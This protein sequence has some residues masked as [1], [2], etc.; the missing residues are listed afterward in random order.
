MM[1]VRIS[2]PL[3]F[4]GLL[5]GTYTIAQET[6]SKEELLKKARTTVQADLQESLEKLRYV[7]QP[8]L[9]KR[10]DYLNADGELD[11]ESGIPSRIQYLDETGS[12]VLYIPF[13]TKAAITTGAVRLQP[14]GDLG[15]DLTGKGLTVGIFD[16]TRPK[17]DHVEFGTRLS[18]IDGSSEELSTHATHVTGTVLA[19][20]INAQARGMAYEATGWAFNWESDVSKMNANAYDPDTKTD[21][22]LISNH[23][24]GVVLGWLNEGGSWT[25]F[26]NATVDP[27]RDWRFGFYSSKSRAL[28]EV[29]YVKPYY[30]VVWAAGNDR[31]DVGDGTRDPDGPA[32]TIGP[33][34]V[35]KN[36]LT[37][38][39][40]EQV[41]DYQT[42][43]DV[44]MS[45]FSGWGPADDGRIKPDLVAMGVSVFSTS[46]TGE[47][48]DSY[49]SQSGTSMAA[50][51]ATGSLFLLQQLYAERNSGRFLLS[52]A[53]KA[54]AIHTARESGP[55]PGP[56][57]MFGWGLLNVADA[58]SLII[59][60]DGNSE[61]IRTDILGEGEVHEFEFISDGV[62]PIRA[63][64]AWTDP[65][66][67]PAGQAADPT[68]LMLVN[69]LDLR[70]FDEDGKEFFPW[71]LDFAQGISARGDQ[72][73]DNFR[74]NVEQVWIPAP[75]PKRYRV[76]ISH[77]NSLEFGV[78]EYALVFSAGAING[79][80]ETLYWI[81]GA[82]GTWNNGANWSASAGGSPIGK[83]PSRTSR[84]VFDGGEGGSA[85]V[86]FPAN[87]EAFSV[88]LFGDQLV[89]FDL[90]GN[91]IHL[92]NGFR[93]S[94]QITQ[95]K[96]GTLH[97][98]NTGSNVQLVDFGQT[99]FDGVQLNFAKGN[100][101]L[102]A[103]DVL[104][105]VQVN[106]ARLEVAFENF[107]VRSMELL[108]TGVLE[109]SF[110]TLTFSKDLIVASTAEI[111]PAI[112]AVFSGETGQFR[113]ESNQSIHALGVSSGALTLQSDKLD[114]LDIENASVLMGLASG[115]IQFLS[116]GAS[117]VLNLG[118]SGLLTIEQGIS[119]DAGSSS[120]ASIVAASKGKLSLPRYQK[121][122]FEHLNVTNVDLEGR[123]IV[124]LGTAASI[125]NSTGWLSQ[126]CQDVLFANFKPDFL[127]VGAAVSFENLSEGAIDAYVWDF[128]GQGSS[129]LKE[130]FFVFDAAGTYTVKL[131][132]SNESGNTFIEQ[133]VEIGT[134][135]LPKPTLVANGSSLTSQQPGS[136]YQWYLDG[137]AIAGATARSFEATEDGNYRV[138]IFD[139]TCN[140]ISDPVVISAIPDQEKELARFGIFVGPV[141]SDDT[142]TLNMVNAYTGAVNLSLIGMDGRVYQESLLGKNREQLEVEI[143]LPA[144]T[145]IYI[146]RIQTETL[147][148]H[149]KVIKQ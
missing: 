118:A 42:P 138:A 116:M 84:V 61:F 3:L 38:G 67:S 17:P 8:G 30:S 128:G 31:D 83:V 40:V 94:N 70:I 51:N 144:H 59:N 32:D 149:K 25:W 43:N 66:G 71:S 87:A 2:I 78:Q 113:Q 45:S 4:F 95:L 18:Q 54:L 114:S 62:K 90:M 127:C 88:N 75:E 93:V 131:T 34:G 55:S 112:R 143:Q 134:N 124:N 123:A 65:A 119:S 39:A 108:G 60:E 73:K 89:N 120:K 27:D 49:V 9:E 130:P 68:N 132:I 76:R 103:A 110:S 100:W 136:A 20:G 147:T 50:P 6:L 53:L 79:A 22:M 69:D 85:T 16:Q 129:S 29:M 148:L 35:A 58:A 91:Q 145:G 99:T 48:A 57:Y 23:S 63:T 117:S 11:L 98:E 137:M 41:L 28:D 80:E 56:D 105:D 12:P 24:Y 126:A 1:N 13:N 97:F 82:S 107:Q 26:G 37:I 109:G 77:K 19:A 96:N 141:P 7:R 86:S 122:C 5:C 74:D 142:I 146:L 52:S 64:I 92:E 125:S 133:G 47:G 15:V 21:G 139:E 81:G 101:R 36:N 44:K 104:G 10:F 106:E 46:I 72:S 115:T 121:L 135:A 102:I 14:G 140:R 111:K 33:E